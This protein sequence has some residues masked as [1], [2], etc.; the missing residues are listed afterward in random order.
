MMGIRGVDRS[1]RT[2][3]AH[4]H[5]IR[6]IIHFLYIIAVSLLAGLAIV[7]YRRAPQF[8]LHRNFALTCLSLISWLLTLYFLVRS[9]DS[10]LLTP[11]GRANFVSVLLAVTF[12][13]H[14]V[15][16]LARIR[17]TKRRRLFLAV[18]T[19]VMSALTLFTPLIDRLE[20]VRDG[21]H[22]TIIGPLF[23]LFA[24]HVTAYPVAAGVIGL[25]AMRSA[26]AHVRDQLLFVAVGILVTAGVNVVTGIVL[27]YG[28]G[29]FSY[30]EV[31]ALSAVVFVGSVAYAILVDRLF[32]IRVVIKKTL[33]IA[34]LVAFVEQ[35]YSESISLFINRVPGSESSP[36][37]QHAVSVGTVLFIAA[38]FHP[39]KEWLEK[40]LARMFRLRHARRT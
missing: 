9:N 19:L 4:T 6:M 33:V 36:L 11:I 31:G 13:F 24:L 37:V 38:T 7:V 35:V 27:P 1:T 12:S 16:D 29:I 40:Q 26:R 2:C 18:E 25:R 21:D 34:L 22:V 10:A 23:V 39:L 5:L 30:E 8:R 17:L 28:Y 3:A 20:S 32:D 15:S 14:F